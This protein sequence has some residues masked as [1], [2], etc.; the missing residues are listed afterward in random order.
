[1]KKIAYL[2]IAAMSLVSVASCVKELT[3]DPALECSVT[4]KV[5]TVSL[6]AD[7]RTSLLMGRK[8][9]W[10]E[11]D[12]LWVS[13]GTYSEAIQVPETAWGRKEFEFVT[14]VVKDTIQGS[15][16]FVVYPYSVAA[17]VTDDKVNI[18]VP[19][20][21]FGQFEDA[22]IMAAVSKD[23]KVTMRNVTALFKITVAGEGEAA[24]PIYSLAVSAAEGKPITGKC[25]IDLS[26]ENPVIT[27][28]EMASPNATVQVDGLPGDYY[29]SVIPGTFAPG[30]KV[31][32]AT[33]EFEHASETK[34]STVANTV[35]ASQIVDLGKIGTNL[36]PLSGEGTEANPYLIESAGHMI[37]LATTVNQ[38]ETFADTYFKV[39][40]DIEGITTVIGY[41]D[42]AADEL[43]TFNGNFDGNGKTLSLSIN[44]GDSQGLFGVLGPNAVVHNMT[45]AG[46][47]VG[48]NYV[49]ALAGQIFLTEDAPAT[50]YDVTSSAT[51][52]GNN[53]VGGLVGYT[54]YSVTS[55]DGTSVTPT[56]RIEIRNC[57]NSGA[58]TGVDRV[59]GVVSYVYYGK[60]Q[61]CS[62]SGKVVSTSTQLSA[63]YRPYLHGTTNPGYVSLGRSQYNYATGGVVGWAQ[64][65]SVESLTNSGEVLGGFKVGGVVGTAFWT[66]VKSCNNSG[67]VTATL[68]GQYSISSQ[69]GLGF[70]SI[71][72][73]VIGWGLGGGTYDNCINVG[74]VKGRGG[75]G[76]IVGYLS[77]TNSAGAIFNVTNCTNKGEIIARDVYNGGG[78]A[79]LG[80]NCSTGGI[81]GMNAS[82]RNYVCNI[83]NCVNEGNVSADKTKV[84]GI[85]GSTYSAAQYKS[86]NTIGNSMIDGCVNKGSVQ[87]TY[88]VGGILGYAYSR[89]MTCPIV[90]NCSNYG[91][92]TATRSDSDAGVE[93]GG[94]SGGASS[95]FPTY[96]Y[97]NNCHI[98]I[99][100]CVNYGEVNYTT[101]TF[102]KLYAGG[103]VGNLWGYSDVGN[104]VN[105]GHVGPASGTPEEDALQYM[106][107]IA[108]YQTSNVTPPVSSVKYSYYP[109]AEP[110]LDLPVGT[111][112]TPVNTDNVCSFD[113]EGN[114][115]QTVEM[116]AGSF[117]VLV[118]ALNGWSA[119]TVY[120]DWKWEGAKPVIIY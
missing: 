3:P 117:A 22:N 15:H 88:R 115:S 64:N 55:E 4:G 36:Q 76:G 41:E 39:A 51:V 52:N 69:T 82:I 59:A 27:P 31:T 6:P 33:V 119:N 89:H 57:S 14:S 77:N 34:V 30:F 54:G 45:L 103:I 24:A 12:S 106:G 58:V 86:Y 53:Y 26:G 113:A 9:V 92:V 87:G 16:V 108:G 13:N 100:N 48:N 110:T 102:K 83:I 75:Q 114:L 120:F 66:D 112:G 42:T 25:S 28:D 5:F 71:V 20:T 32:A 35:N 18:K 70:G 101:A 111:A 78:A 96:Q 95:Y 37:A 63:I 23:F 61:G 10:A 40:N 85:I 91:T 11:G 93:V 107:E 47:V 104:C 43:C 109:S 116:S 44:G 2:L 46:S 50:V 38:G 19:N 7:T 99:Y 29:I 97:N 72:G 118:E 21:Q 67:L 8:T 105:L 60:V 73:G 17:G 56:E 1:M 90:R 84:G 81:V 49:G 79:P 80:F 62:N 68:S 98:K 94:I 74:T 65:S